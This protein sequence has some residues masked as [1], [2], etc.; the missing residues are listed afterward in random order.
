SY[1]GELIKEIPQYYDS[2][3]KVPPADKAPVGSLDHS[4]DEITRS[5]AMKD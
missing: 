5:M 4:M 1:V 3:E 2:W